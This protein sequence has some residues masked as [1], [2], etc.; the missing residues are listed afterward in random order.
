MS[1]SPP[2]PAQQPSPSNLHAP[3]FPQ[4]ATSPDQREP[5][6]RHPHAEQ[7]INAATKHVFPTH[8]A[9]GKEQE[10]EDE[11]A[12][13]NAKGLAQ[14]KEEKE[15][16]PIISG[17]PLD[18]LPYTP[19]FEIPS[20]RFEPAQEQKE[21]EETITEE[22]RLEE[23]ERQSG[24]VINP[25]PQT[26][27]RGDVS[28]SSSR[29]TSTSVSPDDRESDEDDEYGDRM[30]QSRPGFG[31]GKDIGSVRMGASALVSALNALPWDDEN[32]SSNR[33]DQ[34]SAD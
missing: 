21:E 33:I 34:D 3:P 32:S 17:T 23:E 10:R 25:I 12:L 6:P 16:R 28:L 5:S 9:P 19:A 1:R 14:P 15:E 18:E 24:D 31:A 26:H 2:P 20:V 30:T 13:E 11:Q 27:S 8:P 7:F 29:M 4:P 22:Q